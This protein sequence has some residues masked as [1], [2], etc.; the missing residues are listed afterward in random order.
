MRLETHVCCQVL[1]IVADR[2][3]GT[4]VKATFLYASSAAELSNR[5]FSTIL[6]NRATV[7]MKVLTL[8]FPGQVVQGQSRMQPGPD[9]ERMITLRQSTTQSP[10]GH[11]VFCIG[12]WATSSQCKLCGLIDS[13]SVSRVS[14]MPVPSISNLHLSPHLKSSESRISSFWTRGS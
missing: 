6:I 11:R 3:R 8:L 4:G 2:V 14:N 13:T 5:L 7:Y 1:C 10:K 9:H 12:M